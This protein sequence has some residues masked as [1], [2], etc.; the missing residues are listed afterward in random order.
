MQSV[1][2]R[3]ICISIYKFDLLNERLGNTQAYVDIPKG[4][5]VTHSCHVLRAGVTY[6]MVNRLII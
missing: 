1:S 2:S 3:F 4:E 6:D 5:M